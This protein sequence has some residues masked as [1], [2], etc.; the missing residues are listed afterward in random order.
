VFLLA[1]LSSVV[2]AGPGCV[3]KVRTVNDNFYVINRKTG[4]TKPPSAPDLV[5]TDKTLQLSDSASEALK[6][7]NIGPRPK[8]SLSNVEILEEE[9]STISSLL[10]K[11]QTDPAN[12]TVHFRLGRAYHDFRLYDE[13]L[14]HYHN[15]L[16]LDPK[17]PV[18]Y[19]QTGRLWRDWGSLQLGVDL[20]KKALEIDPGFVEAWNTLGTIH[21]RQGNS[22][23]AQDAYLH[24]LSLDLDLDYVHSNLCF[25]YLQSG[26]LEQAI[27]HGERAT[28]LNPTMLVAHNNLGLAYG[29]LGKLDRSLEEF[30]L[31]GDEAAARNNL[32]LMLLNRGQITESMEQFKLAARMKPYYRDAAANYRRARDLNFQRAREARARLRSFDREAQM[33]TTPCYLGFVA[34][35]NMG[36][37]LL[38]ETLDLLSLLQPPV[39]HLRNST[40]EVDIETLVSHAFDGKE[41]RELLGPGRFRLRRLLVVPGRRRHTVVFYKKGYVNEALELAHRIPGTQAVLRTRT[42][43]PG[44]GIRIRLGRDFARVAKRQLEA[45]LYA[46]MALERSKPET[47]VNAR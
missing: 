4:A 46:K 17:D 2:L 41:F 26:K 20:V 6:I 34:V 39:V 11:V 44:A 9:N 28:Q 10:R 15:A 27:R 8:S 19:E 38:G 32:G 37:R 5:Q 18:Y 30:K 40:V 43:D 13:A 14:R 31:G 1:V 45:K 35:A 36:L 47:V 23:Q 24:A 12:A 22:E 3:R 33:E 16:R 21:D 25:S 42:S 29:M 7:A